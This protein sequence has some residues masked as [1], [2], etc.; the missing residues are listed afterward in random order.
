MGKEEEG[1]LELTTIVISAYVAHNDVPRSDLAGLIASTYSALA[2]LGTKPAL[3]P[4]P[5]PLVPA[6]PIKKSVTPDAIICLEDGKAFKSL[7]RHLGTAY[8]LTPEQYRAK[9]GLPS[10]YPMVAPTYSEAR[11]A[12]AK[13]SGLGRKTKAAP[14]PPVAVKRT[15]AK[16]GGPR[17]QPNT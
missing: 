1:L 7:R 2:K 10:D 5:E 13:A 8:N 15:R 12:L 17:K 14:P 16:P 11:A 9:W 3:M 6:V 4:A